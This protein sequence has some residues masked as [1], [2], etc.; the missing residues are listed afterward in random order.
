MAEAIYVDEHLSEAI[1]AER[2]TIAA[3]TPPSTARAIFIHVT[4]AFDDK[5]IAQGRETVM[6]IIGA[7]AAQRASGA[8][9]S[10]DT[11]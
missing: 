4:P 7:I 2:P 11:E 10:R 1:P 3:G 6:R 8:T 9:T 5:T